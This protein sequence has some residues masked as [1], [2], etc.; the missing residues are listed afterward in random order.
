MCELTGTGRVALPPQRQTSRNDNV[1]VILRVAQNVKLLD[2]RITNWLDLLCFGAK[3]TI[4]EGLAVGQEILF[5]GTFALDE[6][7]RR[8]GS[9]AAGLKV[10]VDYLRPGPRPAGKSP[11]RD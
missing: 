4:A 5:R 6:Y 9:K 7:T 8:D 1:Y 11:S 3:A 10:D 2:K